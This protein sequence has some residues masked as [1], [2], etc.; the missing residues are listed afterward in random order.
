MFGFEKKTVFRVQ[1]D[2]FDEEVPHAEMFD[3]EDLEEDD[4][5]AVVEGKNVNDLLARLIERGKDLFDGDLDSEE[6]SDVAEYERSY[7]E[8]EEVDTA[9]SAISAY[10][11]RDEKES[12][13]V[14]FDRETIQHLPRWAQDKHEEGTWEEFVKGSERLSASFA[15]PGGRSLDTFNTSEGEEGFGLDSLTV[16]ALAN[17]Y[18]LPME[19]VLSKM[20]EL[21][22]ALP[23]SSQ[24]KIRDC[25]ESKDQ[26]D[27]LLEM[28]TSFD[29]ADLGENYSE[30]TVEDLAYEYD[31]DT[32]LLV[33]ICQ[34]ED[35]YLWFKEKTHLL[36]IDEEIVISHLEGLMGRNSY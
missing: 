13:E 3:E 9:K 8:E 6:D 30:N 18:R 1:T 23:M 24:D 36:K 11:N 26:L 2:A 5:Y 10:Q 14:F 29:S 20:F 27:S 4:D 12:A 35:I 34:S 7:T 21:G 32:D 25:L 15:P 31:F 16:E 22:A 17:D 28:V 33:D 19:L